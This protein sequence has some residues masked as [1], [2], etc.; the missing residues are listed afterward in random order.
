MLNNQEKDTQLGQSNSQ[1]IFMIIGIIVLAAFVMVIRGGG[2]GSGPMLVNWRSDF[3]SAVKESVN[4]GK[5]VLLY[6]T[7]EW[8]PPC[9][10]MK[11]EVWTD[12]EVAKYSNNRFIPVMIDVDKNPAVAQQFRISTIPTIK[13]I[14][15]SGELHHGGFMDKAEMVTLLNRHGIE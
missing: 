5:P 4:T 9:R 2:G 6:V 13:I 15:D 8:C 14:N 7:A 12:S 10:I 3:D 11:S 1:A